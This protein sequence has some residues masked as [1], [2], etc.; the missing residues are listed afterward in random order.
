M[1][2]WANVKFMCCTSETLEARKQGTCTYGLKVS[3]HVSQA[4]ERLRFSIRLRPLSQETVQPWPFYTSN[5]ASEKM[6]QRSHLRFLTECVR[7][8]VS[9]P[10]WNRGVVC[11][12]FWDSEP[13]S[14]SSRAHLQPRGQT[15]SCAGPSDDLTDKPGLKEPIPSIVWRRNRNA[16]QRRGGRTSGDATERNVNHDE[17]DAGRGGVPLCTRDGGG[18]ADACISAASLRIRSDGGFR[19]PSVPGVTPL[20]VP[21]SQ[22]GASPS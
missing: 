6:E 20:H 11:S 7:D 22:R 19:E 13:V 16:G 10:R 4:C 3:I 12:V 18:F 1:L 5:P 15:P 14:P 9:V 2:M 17:A 21:P 8:C